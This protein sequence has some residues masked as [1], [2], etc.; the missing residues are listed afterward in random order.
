MVLGVGVCI[1]VG[2]SI[3]DGDGGLA[4]SLFAYFF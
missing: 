4:C 2:S 1:G 3:G